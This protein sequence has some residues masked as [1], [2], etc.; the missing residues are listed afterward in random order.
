MFAKMLVEVADCAGLRS[1]V[2]MRWE[3]RCVGVHDLDLL[4]WMMDC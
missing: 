2:S 1:L 4:G 3:T